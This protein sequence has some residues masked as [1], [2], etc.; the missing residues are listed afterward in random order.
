MQDS[1]LQVIAQE[2]CRTPAQVLLRWSVQHGFVPV[3]KSDTPRR[4]GESLA[5]K[6]SIQIADARR[7]S[8][9]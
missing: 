9:G 6:D 1:T 8:F 7:R 4:I 3:V 5:Y 2:V